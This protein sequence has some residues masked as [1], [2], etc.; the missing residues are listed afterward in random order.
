MD[1]KHLAVPEITYHDGCKGWYI[2]LHIPGDKDYSLLA[3]G[4]R[5]LPTGKKLAGVGEIDSYYHLTKED[6]EETLRKWLK[7]NKEPWIT[8]I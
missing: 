7:E 4:G 8:N 1:N 6:A 2:A 5:V 3:V